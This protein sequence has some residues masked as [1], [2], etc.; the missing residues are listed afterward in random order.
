MVM[1]SYKY[2]ACMAYFTKNYNNII[3]K[4]MEKNKIKC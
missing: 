3:E 4:E 1:F 2:D